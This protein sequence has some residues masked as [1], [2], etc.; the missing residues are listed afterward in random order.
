MA[1]ELQYTMQELILLNAA[2]WS[3]TSWF[4]TP[5]STISSSI[6]QLEVI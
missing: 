5:R 4:T 6:D 2:P 1:I 3:T